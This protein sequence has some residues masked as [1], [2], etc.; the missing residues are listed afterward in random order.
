MLSFIIK[1][2]IV[3]AIELRTVL[4]CSTAIIF[5]T[6][7]HSKIHFLCYICLHGGQSKTMQ[8]GLRTT[9]VSLGHYFCETY[10]YKLKDSHQPHEKQ[11]MEL[12]CKTKF[13]S[14]VLFIFFSDVHNFFVMQLQYFFT[15]YRI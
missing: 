1:N 11:I 4:Y 8:P 7:W 3:S 12:C 13:L 10:I 9:V 6:V 5:S 15:V 14:A 2:F